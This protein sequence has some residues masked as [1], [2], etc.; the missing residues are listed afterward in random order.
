MI[1]AYG[2]GSV[3][4]NHNP[5][6]TPN[7]YYGSPLPMVGMLRMMG[8]NLEVYDGNTW[9]K[10]NPSINVCLTSSAED[11]LAWVEQKRHEEADLVK[12]IDKHPGLKDAKERFDVMLA[13][14]KE[15]DERRKDVV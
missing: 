10:V 2:S 1:T 6:Y 11:S 5:G 8:T 3:I 12:L 15:Y 13:L 14:V 7:Y 4:V 9:Q